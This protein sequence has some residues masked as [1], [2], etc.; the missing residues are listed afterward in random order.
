L[1]CIKKAWDI[2]LVGCGPTGLRA[3]E[4]LSKQDA[5][6]TLYEGKPS[7]GRKFLVAG[8]GGL[9]LTHSEEIKRFASR[10]KGSPPEGFWTSLLEEFGNQDLRKWALGLGVETFVGTSGRVFPK[11]FQSAHLLRRWVKRLKDHGVLFNTRWKLTDIDPYDGRFTLSF[12]TAEGARSVSHTA[13]ILA[14]GG[15]SWPETGSDAAWVPILK[16]LGIPIQSFASANCGW[17]VNWNQ[18]ILKTA[19]GHPL[20]NL[21]VTA[22]GVSVQGEL[23]ITKTG[24]EGGALYQLGSQ[25]RTMDHPELILDLKPTFSA[26]ELADKIPHSAS[27]NILPI[28]IKK[29]RLSAAAASLLGSHAPTESLIS[30]LPLARSAKGLRIPLTGPRPIAEAISSAGGVSFTALDDTLMVRQFPGLF[31][32]GEMLDW[33]AP[34]GGYLLQGC[35]ATGTRAA[36]GV[37][38]YLSDGKEPMAGSRK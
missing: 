26:Q 13:V 3:A 5:R 35:F 9:N 33:E 30:P 4:V 34:T 20:K 19:E 37:L 16:R 23:L 38:K 8:R 27:D 32:A 21:T 22:D 6:V 7:V 11:Q 14:L 18:D 12:T 2:A 36:Q 29:W 31:V 24:L 10:Y 28:A 25:L 17:D 15:A 1:S